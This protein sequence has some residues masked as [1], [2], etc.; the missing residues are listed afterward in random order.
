MRIVASQIRFD[1]MIRNGRR[2]FVTAP[3]TSKQIADELP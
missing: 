1:K 3:G 2:F